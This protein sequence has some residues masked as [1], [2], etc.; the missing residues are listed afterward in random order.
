YTPDGFL[1]ALDDQITYGRA[2]VLGEPGYGK[3][4]LLQERHLL[5]RG[6]GE[7]AFFV[8]LKSCDFS[9]PVEEV[10]IRL[11]P[12]FS[13]ALR[14]H[15]Q[16]SPLIISFDGFVEVAAVSLSMAIGRL[17]LFVLS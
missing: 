11:D 14:E 16:G 1:R 15:E 4:R 7:R 6:R 3:T 13:D 2:F 5:C 17:N 8:S 12:Q 10:L 9:V